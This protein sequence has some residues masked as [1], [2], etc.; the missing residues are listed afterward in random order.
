MRIGLTYDL[1][2]EY[3]AAGFSEEATAEFDRPD[4]IEA[5]E[6]ALRQLGHETDRVGHL[7]Q[8]VARLAA[9]DRWDLVFNIAEGMFGPA[10]EAQVPALLEAYEIPCTF[11][12]AFLMAVC[13]NK[14]LTKTMVR[15]AGIP[16][17]DS[18][19]VRTLAD[20]ADLSL[21]YP[22]FAKPVGEGTGKGVTPASRIS[23]RAQL[24]QTCAK[25]LERFQQPV[26]VETF[27]PGREFTV[28]L[29]GTGPD[30]SVLGTLEIILRPQAEADAY[31]YV[32]KEKCE[33]LVDYPLVRPAEDPQV[34]EA[35]K[36]ALAA[37]RA[38]GCRDAGRI[39]LRCDASGQPNFIE[40]NPL[41]GL[42]PQHS[43]L[44]MLATAVGMSY[45]EL[46]KRIVDSAGKRMGRSL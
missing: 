14:D 40:V 24:K 25:L 8:L 39:D 32:N 30:A 26:L 11:A 29:L 28:G 34:A 4:T 6:H 1:R 10:R 15:A 27:L 33:E 9:G 3:L 36:I 13:L 45:V 16:T 19:L 42:H 2:E 17:P 18:L 31:S 44:P 37:W 43:D 5:I 46:I 38:L 12:D 22:L 7:K 21:H 35:E 23:S 20:L 41:A